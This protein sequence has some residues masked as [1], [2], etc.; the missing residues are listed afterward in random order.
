[1]PGLY[2]MIN[3]NQQCAAHSGLPNDDQEAPSYIYQADNLTIHAHIVLQAR[4][5]QP[6]H[7]S[8]LGSHTGKEA[9]GDSQ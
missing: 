9:S 4:P 6:Q 3:M 1:M 2:A 7:R 8:L 5:N